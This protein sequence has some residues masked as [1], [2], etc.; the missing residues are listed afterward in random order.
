MTGTAL[1]LASSPPP[2]A[3]SSSP[4]E[5]R[6][7]ASKR[8]RTVILTIVLA[9][10]TGALIALVLHPTG[11]TT[12]R[13]VAPGFS[14]PDARKSDTTVSLDAA[15]GHPVV[16]TFLASWCAPCTEELPMFARVAAGGADGARFIGVDTKDSDTQ[17]PKLLDDTGVGFPVGADPAGA[18]AER[19]QVEGMPTT[20]FIAADGRID[21]TVTGPL[22]GATLARHLA[23]ITKP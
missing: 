1:K 23:R 20:V 19:Y 4:A 6:W 10:A 12:E 15:A 22:D 9:S 5:H 2:S 17:G 11:T 21:E 13:V 14:L 16:L 18:V 7:L 3:A 8:R